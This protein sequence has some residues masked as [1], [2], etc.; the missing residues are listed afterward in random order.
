MKQRLLPCWRYRWLRN[1]RKLFAAPEGEAHQFQAPVLPGLCLG[2]LNTAAAAELLAASEGP[3]APAVRDRLIRESGGN[4]LALLELPKSLT[5]QQ[6]TGHAPLPV[7]LPLS[8]RLQRAFLERIQR[9]PQATQRLLLVAAVEDTSE[10]V[11]ILDAGGELGVDKER[12]RR[13][14]RPGWSR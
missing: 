11:T 3:L 13:P 14:S 9:L 6:L 4:P 5:S 8:A 2:G 7:R 1:P 10:L 12:W